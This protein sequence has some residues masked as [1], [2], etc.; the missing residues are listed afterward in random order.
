MTDNQK[1][2]FFEAVL[3]G[4]P[5][6]IAIVNQSGHIEWV[7]MAWR[8]FATANG[9]DEHETGRHANYLEICRRAGDDGDETALKVHKGF[10]SVI[11]GASSE[12]SHEYP[13]SPLDSTEELW[14]LMKI[15]PLNDHAQGMLVVL[16]EDITDRKRA[17]IALEALAITDPLTGLA[18]RRRLETA[19]DAEINHAQ[20]SGVP[21]SL[22]M[23]DIDYFKRY[24]D[25]YGHPAGDACLERIGAA[26][27]EVAKRPND[28]AARYGGEEF[29]ILWPQ[30][31]EEDARKLAEDLLV[32]I[33]NLNIKHVRNPP[34]NV[35]TVSIGLAT[36]VPRRETTNRDL[37]TLADEALYEA[38]AAGRDQLVIAGAPGK[39]PLTR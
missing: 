37:I 24:N 27:A 15:R 9:G 26:L 4:M 7:N 34:G 1:P 30:T 13:C 5:N 19:L 8:R 2:G 35:I 39:G 21:L 14:F 18:N 29:A 12:F 31:G 11:S 16:H 36:M 20:R 10:L 28:I 17:E 32:D 25:T 33:R 38:K 23:I 6:H 22:L 3:D